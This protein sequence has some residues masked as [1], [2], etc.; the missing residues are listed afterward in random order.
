MSGKLH[1]VV[2][3]TAARDDLNSLALWLYEFT[4]S[5]ISV[6]R[7]LQR[8]ESAVAKLADNPF[9]GVQGTQN[10]TRELYIDAYRVVYEVLDS[11]VQILAIMH[12]TR[13]YP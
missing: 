10:G 7:I 13:Q 12:C 8:I 1:K 9:L 4:L 5:L 6:D 11:E 3:S 2:Y